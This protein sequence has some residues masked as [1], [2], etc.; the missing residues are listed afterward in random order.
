MPILSASALPDHLYQLLGLG[1]SEGP[2]VYLSQHMPETLHL[3]DF[4]TSAYGPRFRSRAARPAV[5]LLPGSFILLTCSR[6]AN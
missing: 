4:R 5:S 2:L 1:E 6:T 3:I